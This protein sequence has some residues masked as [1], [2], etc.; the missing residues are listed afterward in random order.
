M[1]RSSPENLGLLGS[2]ILLEITI[3]HGYR[4]G[5][6]VLLPKTEPIL[7]E[8]LVCDVVHRDIV[9]LAEGV[10]GIADGEPGAV[11]ESS[12]HIAPICELESVHQVRRHRLLTL[13]VQVVPPEG[14]HYELRI[15]TALA[16][17]HL[18]G[19]LVVLASMRAEQDDTDAIIGS[20]HR[21]RLVITRHQVE[22]HLHYAPQL[23]FPA[24]GY[25]VRSV[26]DAQDIFPQARKHLHRCRLYVVN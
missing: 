20:R 8:H 6:L 26:V 4:T 10:D 17:I 14:V 3:F 12:C 18:V 16:R 15:R 24:G 13:W 9:K 1:A 23:G 22:V 19:V 11:A 5:V 7:S 25:D 21:H 2:Y